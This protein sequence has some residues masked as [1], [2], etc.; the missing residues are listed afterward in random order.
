MLCYLPTCTVGCFPEFRLLPFN[1]NTLSFCW[2]L[3]FMLPG[4]LQFKKMYNMQS[5]Y[6]HNQLNTGI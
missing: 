1:D 5:K 2:L 4:W 6:M 3:T